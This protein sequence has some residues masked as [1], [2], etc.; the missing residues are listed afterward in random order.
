M[1]LDPHLVLSATLPRPA[2]IAAR[3]GPVRLVARN[4]DG[5][6]ELE[7]DES[8]SHGARRTRIWE[9]DASLHCSIVGTCLTTTELR[10]V[11]DKLKIGATA[12]DHELH[13]LGVSLAGR[14]EAGA[15]FLQKALDRRHRVAVTR[16]SKAKDLVALAALWAES[17]KQGDIPGSYWAVLTHPL[18]NEELVKQAFGDVHMLSHLVGAANR[19]DIRRL[20]ELEQENAVLADKIERQQRR[21]Q[22]GFVERDRTIQ[23]LN[24]MLAASDRAESAPATAPNA[25]EAADGALRDLNRR[26]AREI[27]R[28]ERSEARASQLA[29]TLQK[30]DDALQR[31]ERRSETIERELE[32]IEAHLAALAEPSTAGSADPLD[33]SG[34]TVLY[35]GGR[36]HQTPQ[37]K[38]LIEGAGGR[39]LHHDGGLEQSSTLLPGMIGRA[40]RVL[41]P[42][43][44][45]S[46]EA[47]ATIKRVCRGLG[48]GYEPL[49]TASLA[50]VLAALLRMRGSRE[51]AEAQ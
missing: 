39:F 31:S 33:V 37:I 9:F 2:P 45:V 6:L 12:S 35:V 4:Q 47:V 21:L 16:C 18:A 43:D 49:R 14:R 19:A 42:I 3:R 40:D 8:Q 50:C 48:R 28:R 7:P 25:D 11:L 46:H 23:R 38:G 29:A 20:R 22:E 41:F 13:A 10:H 36:A 17:L 26:L 15:K 27:A 44:C 5:A 24:E 51:E 32:L 30:S 1:A 34:I